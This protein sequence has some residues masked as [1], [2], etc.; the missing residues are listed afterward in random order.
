MEKLVTKSKAE[1]MAEAYAKK[2]VE[3]LKKDGLSA[4]QADLEDF[5]ST[6]IEIYLAG[7]KAMLAEAIRHSMDFPF[8]GLTERQ[9]KI[10]DLKKILGEQDG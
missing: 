2:E 6:I 1:Q 7:M 9:V 10:S 3:Q 5:S 8:H 4:Y